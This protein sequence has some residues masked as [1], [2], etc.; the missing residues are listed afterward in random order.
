MLRR[1]KNEGDI[2]MQ[3]CNVSFDFSNPIE[4]DNSQRSKDSSINSCASN[5]D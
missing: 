3:E 1:E 4:S 2:Q 5:V